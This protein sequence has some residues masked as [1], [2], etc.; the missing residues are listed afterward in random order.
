MRQR[1]SDQKLSDG[2]VTSF[3]ENE[4]SRL[5]TTLPSWT[6]RRTHLLFVFLFSL[7]VLAL[8]LRV[9][10]K[11]ATMNVASPV[12]IPSIPSCQDAKCTPSVLRLLEYCPLAIPSGSEGNL[13]DNNRNFE[14]KHLLVTIRHGDR[15]AIHRIPGSADPSKAF[16]TDK[17][18]PTSS[19]YLDASVLQY[20]QRMSAFRL[21]SMKA[22]DSTP[23]MQSL[24]YNS[25]KL[26]KKPDFML[27]QGQLTSRGFMQHISLGTILRKAYGS[28]LSPIKFPSQIVVR[29]TNYDRTIQSVA[30]FLT[31]LLPEVI[32]AGVSNLASRITINYFAEERYAKPLFLSPL[33]FYH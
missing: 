20:V 8:C 26:F 13:V 5:S 10:D 21:Q 28:F 12:T 3:R 2:M 18:S 33:L 1:L 15:S 27:D 24:D 30:A 19:K 22:K 6:R 23:L 32:T 31:A 17:G 7:I 25:T 9:G 16:T 14:L 11:V 29:S 4:D